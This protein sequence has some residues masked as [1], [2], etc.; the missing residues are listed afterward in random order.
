MTGH[1][2]IL[3]S[4]VAAFLLV[5]MALL[6]PL[7]A[8][9]V[10]N[11]SIA[12]PLFSKPGSN[13]YWEDVRSAGSSSVPI[14]IANPNNGPGPKADPV[15]TDAIAK[16][17]E[18]KIRTLGYVQTNFQTRPFKDVYQDIDNW[19][20]FYPQTSG[21][22]IDL[23]KEGGQDEVCYA[24]ALYSHIK[25]VR[26][27]DLVILSPG[28]HISSAYE[29]YA[30]IFVNANM[31]YDTYKSWR[32]QH[33]GFEDRS[34]YQNRFWHMIYG[35]DQSRYSEAFSDIRDNNAGWVFMTDK[36][37]PTPFTA[38]PLFWQNEASD[39]G[40][41][42]ESAIPNRGKTSLPRGCISLSSSADSSVDTRTARQ[43]TTTSSVTV[44][45]TSSTYS[46]EPTTGIKFMSMPKGVAVTAMTSASGWSC[47]RNGMYCAYGGTVPASSSLPLISTT[48]TAGCDYAGGDAL[49]RLTNYTGNQWDLKIPVRA[50]FGCDPSTPAGKLNREDSGTVA[51]LTTQSI[52]TTPEITPLG[53]NTAVPDV[54]SQSAAKTS[55]SPLK[56]LAIIVI[57]LCVASLVAWGIV[58]WRRRS[59]YKVDI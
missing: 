37:A 14:V 26:P 33:K 20:T 45:N 43:S 29:P 46:S 4:G 5:A 25:N 57:V 51:T 22:Y 17:T 55:I 34:Q 9:A 30:D 58:V 44:N 27:N 21:I 13:S 7:K 31:D 3:L 19:Y 52:E 28:T 23:I 2:K 18:A 35:V 39:V 48:V 36:G 56:I 6:S 53:S 16:N 1:L 12:V 24:A 11:Q 49:L 10:T 40:V 41:L 50:P 42:P 8:A 38:T 47:D 32:V 59:R 15:Y 54:Q